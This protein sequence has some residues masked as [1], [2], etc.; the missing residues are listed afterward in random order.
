M[1]LKSEAH[2]VLPLLFQQ[3]GVPP[4]VICDNAKETFLGEFNRKLKEA[5]C[6]L[7]QSELFTSWSTAV[8]REK[9]ELEKGSGRKLIKSGTQ[10]Q[11]W[12]DCLKL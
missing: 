5:S 2:K 12:D 3:D 6:H 11:L 8:K 10:K 1:K 9:K 7:K 4:A